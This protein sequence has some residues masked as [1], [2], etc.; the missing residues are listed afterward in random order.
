VIVALAAVLGA[1]LAL[2]GWPVLR[3]L[4]ARP[5]FRRT[6][7]RG[8]DVA[9][10]GGLVLIAAVVLAEPVLSA[11]GRYGEIALADRDARRAVVAAV[12]GFGL[13]GLLDDLTGDTSTTGYR[14]HLRAL[15]KGEVTT[16]VLKILGGGIVA[17]AVTAMAVDDRGLGWILV[18]AALVA[19]SANL[20]NLLDRRPG[21]TGKVAAVAGAVVCAASGFDPAV[22]GVALVTGATVG[23][24]LPDLREELM[25]GD[26]G[27]NPM[28]A[29][30][31]LGVVIAFG[32]V[33]RVAVLVAVLALNLASERVSFTAVIERTPALRRLDQLGRLPG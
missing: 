22:A 26:T 6:N 7:Y 4:F 12:V 24:L 33:V 30:V 3:S 31:G 17:L 25:I 5:A 32:P 15:L 27:S 28:G 13:L 19:L 18:D 23:L 9:T 2:V 20:A 11:V 8:R 21:R 1:V 16:G 10:A 14:G 29:A